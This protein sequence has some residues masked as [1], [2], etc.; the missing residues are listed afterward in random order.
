MVILPF[1]LKALPFKL[2]AIIYN[3]NI[4]APY[5]CKYKDRGLIKSLENYSTEISLP[6]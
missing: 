6:V 5:P 4:K 2:I 3:I 1:V